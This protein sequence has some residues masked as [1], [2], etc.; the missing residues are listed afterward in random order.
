[1]TKQVIM[2][3]ILIT[4]VVVSLPSVAITTQAS[5]GDHSLAHNQTNVEQRFAESVPAHP[6]ENSTEQVLPGHTNITHVMT[7]HSSGV[8]AGF[9]IGLMAIG[10]VALLMFLSGVVVEARK[11]SW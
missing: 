10:S 8:K 2:R 5:T 7:T 9:G 3:A 6:G 4:I 1:M 11:P